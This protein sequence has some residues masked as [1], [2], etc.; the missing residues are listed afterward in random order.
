ME[1]AD[2]CTERS[3]RHARLANRSA[4]VGGAGADATVGIVSMGQGEQKSMKAC[5]ELAERVSTTA[6]LPKRPSAAMGF[7]VVGA[8]DGGSAAG[9]LRTDIQARRPV[10]GNGAVPTSLTIVFVVRVRHATWQHCSCFSKF[11]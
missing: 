11:F 9:I 10:A 5:A 7:V 3:V 2:H 8:G 1:S 4:M 6:D